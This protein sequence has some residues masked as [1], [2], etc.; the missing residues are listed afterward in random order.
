MSDGSVNVRWG[1][2]VLLVWCAAIGAADSLENTGDAPIVV[3]INAEARVSAAIGTPL[4]PPP[5]C[6]ASYRIKINVINQGFVTAPLRV[7]LVGDGGR[8]VSISADDTKLSGAPE[9]TR[10]LQLTPKVSAPIDVTLAFSVADSIGDLAGRDRL[11]LLVRC[12]SETGRRVNNDELR[13]RRDAL[14]RVESHPVG[15]WL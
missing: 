8:Y 15:G 12:V 5:Q 13:P 2:S 10:M 9:E 4:P 11:H 7:A 3:T 14:P 6:G 1:V